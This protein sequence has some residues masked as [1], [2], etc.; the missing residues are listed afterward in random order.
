M[1]SRA[2]SRCLIEDQPIELPGISYNTSSKILCKLQ[3][4][5][6][7]LKSA[8]PHKKTKKKLTKN[9]AI[10][11]SEEYGFF[12]NHFDASLDAPSPCNLRRSVLWHMLSNALLRMIRSIDVI[13]FLSIAL[14][15][16][17]VTSKLRFSVYWYL[18]FPLWWQVRLPCWV[19]KSLNWF[20]AIFS[21]TFERYRKCSL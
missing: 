21:V 9:Q 16:W 13:S 17:P 11:N 8:R 12:S 7:L 20:K 3:F 6:F 14:K 15:I 19:R 2:N 5:N 10:Q 18:R 4:M 1:T